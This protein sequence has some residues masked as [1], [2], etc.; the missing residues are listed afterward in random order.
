MHTTG[1]LTFMRGI[2]CKRKIPLLYCIHTCT[3]ALRSKPFVPIEEFNKTPR[4]FRSAKRRVQQRTACYNLG[5]S[6]LGASSSHP[7]KFLSSRN[8]TTSTQNPTHVAHKF[9]SRSCLLWYQLHWIEYVFT[10]HTVVNK[11]REGEGRHQYSA[12]VFTNSYRGRCPKRDE[13][14]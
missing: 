1:H 13:G 12:R 7:P 3:A 5:E 6:H 8:S 9:L 14:W 4:V 2:S 10:H 11:K